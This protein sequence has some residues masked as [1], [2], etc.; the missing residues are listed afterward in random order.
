M[1]GNAE[2]FE[3]AK[4]TKLRSIDMGVTETVTADYQR[5][6]WKD[7]STAAYFPVIN[8]GYLTDRDSTFDVP[9]E[10]LRPAARAHI[11]LERAFSSWGLDLRV[12]GSLSRLWKKFVL[13]NT[14]D[15]IQIDPAS[16]DAQ[17]AE[18]TTTVPFTLTGPTFSQ[19]F[20]FDAPTITQDPSGNYTAPGYYTVPT[21]MTIR[22]VLTIDIGVSL[23]MSAPNGFYI[24]LQ[25]A[26]FTA[27]NFIAFVPPILRTVSDPNM[28]GVFDFGTLEVPSGH[29]IGLSFSIRNFEGTNYPAGDVEFRECSIKWNVENVPYG[30]G[31][32]LTVSELY[33]DW[34]V[35]QLLKTLFA[36]RCLVVET[37][38][39]RGTVDVWQ[40][41]EYFQTTD[42]GINWTDR[43]SHEEPPV[44][45]LP[46]PPVRMEFRFKD[47]SKDG[48]LKA[49]NDSVGDPG[50]GNHDHVF[51]GGA[52]DVKKVELL[53]AATAMDTI[54]KD[55]VTGSGLFVPTMRK[56]DGT[57]QEDDYDREPRILIANRISAADWS[58]A[59]EVISYY[60]VC[61]FIRSG[62]PY[63]MAFGSGAVYGDQQGGTAQVQYS[64]R[65]QR[66]VS[67]TLKALTKIYPDEVW[68]TSFGVPRLVSDGFNKVWCYVVN[69]DQ[70]R[71]TGDTLTKTTFIPL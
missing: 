9:V 57:A 59:G 62:E 12:N 43:I 46:I 58:H 36:N 8:Y 48:D 33:P 34:T 49:V 47:D 10:R 13:P 70:F 69:I 31:Y 28:S 23:A 35:M 68:S 26:D 18:F 52:G 3:L 71:F 25:I 37:N 32:A 7:E 39:A 67:P 16:I 66:M 17:S 21:A 50:Y 60:P 38:A 45:M 4:S 44:K 30:E 64:Y 65:L 54:L 42:K 63:T 1:G 55:D 15:F 5:R 24:Y 11:G 22:P 56:L 51:D 40:D 2:W 41:S 14:R 27:G 61:Y 53:C 6:S 20:P 19:P 29:N